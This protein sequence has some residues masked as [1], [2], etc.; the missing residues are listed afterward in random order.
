[1]EIAK[2]NAHLIYKADEWQPIFN[3]PARVKDLIKNVE[4]V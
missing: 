4:A 1:M 3:D 2:F